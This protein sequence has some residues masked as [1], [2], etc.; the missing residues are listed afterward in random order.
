MKPAS[1]ASTKQQKDFKASR[2]GRP[3]RKRKT[4]REQKTKQEATRIQ[5]PSDDKVDPKRKS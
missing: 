4:L 3:K 2:R 1:E 5:S